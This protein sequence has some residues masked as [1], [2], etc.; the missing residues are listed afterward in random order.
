MAIGAFETFETFEMGTPD[1]SS[2]AAYNP[3][4]ALDTQKERQVEIKDYKQA[5]A[6]RGSHPGKADEM[7]ER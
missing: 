5:V 3:L 1:S 4:A 2:L 6:L 7:H